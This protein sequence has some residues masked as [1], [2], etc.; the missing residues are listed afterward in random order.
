MTYQCQ[1]VKQEEEN[2]SARVEGMVDSYV[3]HSVLFLFY[4]RFSPQ[5][6][7]R[8]VHHNHNNA[9]DSLVS[10]QYALSNIAALYSV[11]VEAYTSL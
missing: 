6:I 9:D 5:N 3:F 4:N 2:L 7:K 10:V 11:D 1:S 8:F